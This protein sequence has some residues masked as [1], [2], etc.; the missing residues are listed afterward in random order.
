MH[1]ISWWSLCF[2]PCSSIV[3]NRTHSVHSE[4]FLFRRHRTAFVSI[5]RSGSLIPIKSCRWKH[6]VSLDQ[7]PDAFGQQKT[8]RRGAE[9][10]RSPSH[11]TNSRVS[12]IRVRSSDHP[13]H[14][15]VNLDETAGFCSKWAHLYSI[16]DMLFYGQTLSY[17]ETQWWHVIYWNL[18]RFFNTFQACCPEENDANL[19]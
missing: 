14:S 17:T 4:L 11:M 10:R 7:F 8:S 3:I 9:T 2:Y 16:L 13:W 1:Q 19:K 5:I 15:G 18:F 12:S 6:Y